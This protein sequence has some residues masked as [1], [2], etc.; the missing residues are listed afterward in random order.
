[1]LGLQFYSFLVRHLQTLPLGSQ[2]HY[3][4]NTGS[5]FFGGGQGIQYCTL[6]NIRTPLLMLRGEQSTVATANPA[7]LLVNYNQSSTF[8]KIRDNQQIHRAT[9]T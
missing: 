8:R 3:A 6:G 9:P 5:F 4:E 7:R 1:M 2:N